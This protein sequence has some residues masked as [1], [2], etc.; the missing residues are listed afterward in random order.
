MRFRSLGAALLLVLTSVSVSEASVCGLVR[1][2]ELQRFPSAPAKSSE[3]VRLSKT[4]RRQAIIWVASQDDYLSPSLGVIL[5]FPDGSECVAN[6]T[7]R[8]PRVLRI[9][10]PSEASV[11]STIEV[12]VCSTLDQSCLPV[13][14]PW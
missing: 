1:V 2:V 14:I 13:I 8:Q 4:G 5:L 12:G 11:P 3:G 7:A 9:S 6:F 10:I